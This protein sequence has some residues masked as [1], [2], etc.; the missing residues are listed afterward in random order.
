MG[1]KFETFTP[2]SRYIL[3]LAEEEAESLQHTTIGT[4]HIL[5]GMIRS[6]YG[7]AGLMLLILTAHN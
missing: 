7:V 1:N 3:S 2:S 6:E 5:L 4:P